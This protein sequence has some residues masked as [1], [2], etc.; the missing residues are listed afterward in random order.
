MLKSVRVMS[1]YYSTVLKHQKLQFNKSPLKKEA[2][3]VNIIALFKQCFRSI[4]LDFFNWNEF[5]IGPDMC[6]V[7][8]LVCD[9]PHI[10][11]LSMCRIYNNSL[12][13]PID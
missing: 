10:M 2:T 9:I 6:S 4:W 8:N 12:K 13:Q 11:C 7:E 5:I 1:D 3:K